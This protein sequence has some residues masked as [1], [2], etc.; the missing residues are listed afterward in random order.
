MSSLLRER[1]LKT[2]DNC[3]NQRQTMK[4]LSFEESVTLL[5]IKYCIP[6]KDVESERTKKLKHRSISA[7]LSVSGNN[8]LLLTQLKSRSLGLRNSPSKII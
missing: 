5:H 3:A 2:K 1:L 8:P 4:S 7:L 6:S